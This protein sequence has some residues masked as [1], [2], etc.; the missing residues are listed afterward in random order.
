MAGGLTCEEGLSLSN[1]VGVNICMG[2]AQNRSEP[3]FGPLSAIILVLPGGSINLSG[4]FP[5]AAS[6]CGFPHNLPL[7]C[8]QREMGI[9]CPT[10]DQLRGSLVK[11]LLL[12]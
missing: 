4:T 10:V 6:W 3:E 2:G 9:S 8:G 11:H 5:G 1:E 7:A 12:A